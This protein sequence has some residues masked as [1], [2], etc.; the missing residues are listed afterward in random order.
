MQLALH[1]CAPAAD[2]AGLR[3]ESEA[4]RAAMTAA[5]A[6]GLRVCKAFEEL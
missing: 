6:E 4:V 3:A 5:E 1:A 2:V